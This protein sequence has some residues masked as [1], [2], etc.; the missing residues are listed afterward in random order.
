MRAMVFQHSAAPRYV[1]VSMTVEMCAGLCLPGG[2]A[3]MG[4]EYGHEW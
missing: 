2:L 1:N 4:V 3:W